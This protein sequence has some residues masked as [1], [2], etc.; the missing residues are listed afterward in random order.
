MKQWRT[1][2]EDEDRRKDA[3]FVAWNRFLDAIHCN[4]QFEKSGEFDEIFEGI[5][6]VSRFTRN[7]MFIRQE[8]C[9]RQIKITPQIA[10]VSMVSDAV[11]LQMGRKL[12][13]WT[14]LEV[15]SV[16]SIILGKRGGIHLT[17]NPLLMGNEGQM[18]NNFKLH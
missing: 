18:P 5:V 13:T 11:Y 6:E 7:S 1:K 17:V 3:L 2:F 4:L 15:I 8:H 14:P 12:G 16:G 9:I 10:N